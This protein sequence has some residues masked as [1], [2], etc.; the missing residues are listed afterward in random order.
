[1][2]QKEKTPTKVNGRS[3]SNRA[4]KG[5]QKDPVKP[6]GQDEIPMRP[7]VKFNLRIQTS[8]EVANAGTEGEKW[9]NRIRQKVSTTEESSAG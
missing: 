3:L 9:P 8:G 1:M 6:P 4:L 5:A 7:A 2:V